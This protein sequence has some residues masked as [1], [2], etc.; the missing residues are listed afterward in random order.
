M[1]RFKKFVVD[2]WPLAFIFPLLLVF[3]CICILGMKASKKSQDQAE[4]LCF[5]YVIL[6]QNDEIVVCAG[7]EE[8]VVKKRK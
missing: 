5:P 6:V 4:K 8:P 7:I 1:S 3:A 2:T